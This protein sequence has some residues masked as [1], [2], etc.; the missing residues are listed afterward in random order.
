M[1][2]FRKLRVRVSRFFAKKKK[3]TGARQALELGQ[4]SHPHDVRR[5]DSKGN[6]VNSQDVPIVDTVGGNAAATTGTTIFTGTPA[7]GDSAVVGGSAATGTVRVNGD[8]RPVIDTAAMLRG[9]PLLEGSAVT[10]GTSTSEETAADG[11]HATGGAASNT[12]VE[13]GAQAKQDT[14]GTVAGPAPKQAFYPYA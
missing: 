7:T 13:A 6:P 11:A 10:D 2:G 12:K 4:I 1:C 8:R 9:V 14:G 3:N 5:V